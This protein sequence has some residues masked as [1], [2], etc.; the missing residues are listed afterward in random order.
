MLA[1]GKLLGLSITAT[2]ASVV[3]WARNSF[4]TRQNLA[5][6]VSSV[7]RFRAF[8]WSLQVMP[9]VEEAALLHLCPHRRFSSAGRRSSRSHRSLRVTGKDRLKVGGDN[10]ANSG[11]KLHIIASNPLKI[12]AF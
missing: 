5:P 10:G 2:K 6:S 1:W 3:P 7:D 8:L 11:F 9:M 12:P 4:I